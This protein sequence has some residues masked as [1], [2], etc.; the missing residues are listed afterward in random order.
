MSTVPMVEMMGITKNFSGVAANDRIRFAVDSGEIHA[1]LGENGAGK[2]TL[3]SVLTGL[4]RPD[5]G[6]IKIKGRKVELT[7]PR[8]AVRRG[9]GMVHQHFKLVQPF[10]VAENIMLGLSGVKQVYDLKAIERE[11]LNCSTTYGLTIDPQARIWQLSVGE[12]QRVEIVKMLFKG[13]EILILDEP[14]AVLTPQETA[15]LYKTLRKMADRGKAVIVISHKLNEVMENTDTITVLRGGKLI[16]T[17]KT[18]AISP[19][20]L[21]RMMVGRDIASDIAKEPAAKGTKV[22]ELQSVSAWGDRGRIAL[23]EVSL[24]V[25]EGEILGVAGVAGNGQRYLAEVIAG[26]RKIAAGKLILR[27]RDHTASGCKTLIDSGVSYIPEDRM[28]TGLVPNL[29]AAENIILKN[30]RRMG[31]CF[32]NWKQIRRYTRELIHRFEVK[33]AG[34][35]FPVKLMSG[36]NLQK[37]LLAREI[38]SDPGLIVAVYPMRGLDIGAADSIRKLLLAQRASAKAIVLISEDLEDLFALSDRIV[39]LH[40]GEIMGVVDPAEATLET[41]GLMMAGQRMEPHAS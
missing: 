6:E 32:I 30:Y 16:G 13:A 7:S 12:Q 36:G 33:A 3:M 20:E 4:Y 5:Q 2:S 23:R 22:L 9:I 19:G 39:V 1:L 10:T 25:S 26:L 21:A 38:E 35:R 18:G 17:V 14:T 15:E 37:L 41:V 31:G 27:D 24:E 40:G 34:P 11:I 29:N 28:T 8:D